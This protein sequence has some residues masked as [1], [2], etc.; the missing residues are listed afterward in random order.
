MA[1]LKTGYT[2]RGDKLQHA[3]SVNGRR[4]Y[5]Y[6]ATYKECQ[7]K[8]LAKREQIRQGLTDKKN[9]T[10]D[11]Y[12][13]E[14]EKRRSG[15]VKQSTEHL[16][17]TRYRCHI[18]PYLGRRKL[19][20]IERK[21]ISSLQGALKD[22]GLKASTVN[23]I[24]TQLHTILKGAC[25]DEILQRNPCDYMPTLKKTG[26][27][28]RET[29]HRALTETE[30]NTFLKFADPMYKPLLMFL[31]HTGMR[32]G[33]ACALKWSDIDYKKNLINISMTVTKDKDGKL[34][35]GEAKT[36][37][38][39]RTIPLNRNIVEALHSQKEI[40]HDLNYPLLPESFVFFNGHGKMLRPSTINQAVKNTLKRA[41][42]AGFEIEHFSP[43]AFRDTF[44]TRAVESGMHPET[45]QQILGHA[46]I[47]MTM[48]LYYHLTEE[49]KQAEMQLL[50]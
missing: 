31:L 6:G 46:K 48:D 18:S 14:W 47:S 24:I 16:T 21:D 43:H 49:K 13:K 9:I 32:E 42:A 15:T 12:F 28:A 2:K 22:E 33:E 3:F 41:R 17:N 50:I 35:I 19:Q 10:L 45:L 37:T 40:A 30:S 44:A 1:R 25:M 39:Q 34:I 7:E 36:N 23:I 27:Q 8:E 4:Y 38:S 11:T 29:I 20:S 5:V 26:K